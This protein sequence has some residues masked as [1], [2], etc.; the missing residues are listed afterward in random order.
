MLMELSSVPSANGGLTPA[1][2][3][4]KEAP[5]SA[6]TLGSTAPHARG[7]SLEEEAGP[8]QPGSFL[9]PVSWEPQAYRQQST[10]YPDSSSGPPS[11]HGGTRGRVS[12]WVACQTRVSD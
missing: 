12:T 11:I 8:A 2:V 4:P 10:P 1:V 9:S 6:P 7:L 3:S 5:G